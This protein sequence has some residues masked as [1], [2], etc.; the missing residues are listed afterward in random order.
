[1]KKIFILA[2]PILLTA[3]DKSD[4]KPEIEELLEISSTYQYEKEESELN[5][6][7]EDGNWEVVVQTGRHVVRKSLTSGIPVFEG[8]A[9]VYPKK[10]E[11]KFI[12][13][14]SYILKSLDYNQKENIGYFCVHKPIEITAEEI[15]SGIESRFKSS[16]AMCGLMDYSFN[17]SVYAPLFYLKDGTLTSML[18]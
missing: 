4:N 16:D 8:F 6:R 3:C 17:N 10:S 5:L 13:K 2:I 1:M 7:L 14:G 18:K 9:S 15:S 12:Q 11:P